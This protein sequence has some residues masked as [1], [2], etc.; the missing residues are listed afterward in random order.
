MQTLI[1]RW[2][3]VSLLF[4][5]AAASP[6]PGA[7][8]QQELAVTLAAEKEVGPLPAGPLFWQVE[9]FPT[10]ALAEAAAGPTSLVLAIDGGRGL[11]F[12]LGRLGASKHRGRTVAEI[13]PVPPMIAPAYLLQAYRVGGPPGAAIPVHAHLGSEAFYVLAGRMGQRTSRGSRHA[14][15]GQSMA[16]YGAEPP[17]EVF[18]SGPTGL[19]AVLLRL[20]PLGRSSAPVTSERR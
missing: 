13:G 11:V 9:D 18:N 15:A 14:A 8:A 7:L 5:W 4:L 20:V 19:S 16:G 12:T 10:L 1:R 2:G 3:V 6:A 17:A